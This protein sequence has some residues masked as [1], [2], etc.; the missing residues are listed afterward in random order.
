MEID[1]LIISEIK[2]NLRICKIY[3]MFYFTAVCST[4]Q[5]ASFGTEILISK[6]WRHRVHSHNVNSDGFINF[7][8]R[9]PGGYLTIICVYGHE[10]GR[11]KQNYIVY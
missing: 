9:I 3:I 1:I 2:M 5:R 10:E 6:E 7:F 8:I 11:T 4:T